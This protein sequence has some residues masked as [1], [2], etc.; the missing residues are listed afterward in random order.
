MTFGH[1]NFGSQKSKFKPHTPT[2][3]IERTTERTTA[4]FN[5]KDFQV[6]PKM[7]L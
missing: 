3:Y 1:V 5:D 2:D 7:D 6:P 4:K